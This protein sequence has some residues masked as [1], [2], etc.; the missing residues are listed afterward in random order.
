M[1]VAIA[2]L[3][4]SLGVLIAIGIR[5]T[6]NLVVGS[7]LLSVPIAFFWN[8]SEMGRK[9]VVLRKWKP[10][11]QRTFFEWLYERNKPPELFDKEKRSG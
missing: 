3:I 2:S 1:V 6:F 7:V 11:I 10:L 8:I 5:S 4:L 9:G